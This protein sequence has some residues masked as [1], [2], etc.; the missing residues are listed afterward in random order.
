MTVFSGHQPNF[1]PYMGFFYKMFKSDFFVLDDDVQY[2]SSGFHNTNFIK[3]KKE[4]FQMTVPVSYSTGDLI[5]EV[6]ICYNKPWDRKL[7]KTIEM[8]YKKAPYFE[9]GFSL[10]EKHLALKKELLFDLNLGL[11]KEIHDKFKIDSKLILASREFPT[12][13]KNNERNVY[14]GTKLN[15][16]VYYSGIG[17]KEYNDEKLYNYSLIKLEYSD[18]VPVVYG[19]GKGNFI[20]NLSVL[21]YIFYN[22]Y[23]LPTKWRK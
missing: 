18:Y 8:S 5:N 6:R 9:E 23:N 22:G 15:A 14:Q 7:L 13:L 10:I 11:I 16:T 3:V 19:Q 12:D 17:G 21:D 20:E 2:S 1:L 4:K